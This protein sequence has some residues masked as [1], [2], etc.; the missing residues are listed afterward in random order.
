VSDHRVVITDDGNRIYLTIYPGG[1]TVPLAV[2]ELTVERTVALA[3]ELSAIAT[4]YL[5]RQANHRI[6]VR[7]DL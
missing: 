2:V 6:G 1:A 4:R 5:A 3:A 7:R